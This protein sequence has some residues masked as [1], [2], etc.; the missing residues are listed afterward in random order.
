MD[1]IVVGAGLG[2][3]GAGLALAEMGATVHLVEALRYPGG[4]AS[5]FSKAGA[6]FDAGATLLGGLDSEGVFGRWIA[7]YAPE[8]RVTLDEALVELRAPGLALTV[9][10]SRE[11]LVAAFVELAPDPSTAHA[12][13]RFFA[14]QARVA[15]VLWRLL[16]DPSLL[17]PFSVAMLARHAKNAVAYAPVLRWIGRPLAAVLEAHG[18]ARFA[19]LRTYLDALCQITVQCSAAEAEAPFAMA[20]MDYYF[21]GAGHLAGGVGTLA[22][23]LV[24]AMQK[25]G[26]TVSYSDRASAIV[27]HGSSWEVISRRGRARAPAVIAN[28]VP[29][30]LAAMLDPHRERG[31][32]TEL[33]ARSQP[34][35]RAW[36]AAMLY[37]IA[38][39][40]ALAAAARHLE[41]VM[42]EGAP[43]V[44]GNHVFVSTSAEPGRAP[45]GRVPL[46]MSTHVPLERLRALEGAKR[47]EYI[48]E[49]QA[50]MR[51]TLA[52]RAP[53]WAEG[54]ETV[55]PASPRTF[56]R[57]VGRPHGAVG[58]LPRRHGLESYAQIGPLQVV[59]GIWLVGDS[60]FPG[61]SALA[62]AIGGMRVAEAVRRTGWA[63]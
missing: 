35:E 61:Q 57:F 50:Q 7:R 53:E 51:A 30:A 34:I 59:D 16:Y 33:R 11:A 5:T 14:L 15:E 12:V 37:A 63:R 56:E 45:A 10:R 23:V 8:T 48:S 18:L 28:L 17:P 3:L 9:G 19:P 38:R 2:G 49:V 24:G 13:R 54:L 21:R 52:A 29:S 41:L 39:P 36:G 43:F 58:G 1:V 62:T 42:D 31:A 20:V 44:E 25:L 55:L 22:E 26:A 46:T 40:P 47:A 60:V 4:C 27:R 32:V 6:R